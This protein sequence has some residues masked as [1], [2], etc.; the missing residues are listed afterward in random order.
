M[1][2]YIGNAP[3]ELRLAKLARLSCDVTRFP[4]HCMKS[5]AITTICNAHVEAL[6]HEVNEKLRAMNP[7]Q[8]TSIVYGI[9]NFHGSMIVTL[10]QVLCQ[11]EDLLLLLYKHQGL[12]WFMLM[13]KNWGNTVVH[14]A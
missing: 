1:V 8:R 13:S 12:N 5:T 14:S 11:I 7:K 4:L 9:S 6:A 3:A 10:G 2:A